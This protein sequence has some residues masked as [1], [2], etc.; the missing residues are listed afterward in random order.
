MKN[1]SFKTQTKDK[2]MK[3]RTFYHLVLDKSG[4]MLDSWVEARQVI[5][6]QLKELSRMQ[7]ENPDSEISFSICAFNQALRFSKEIV[8][9]D[10]AE[11]DWGTIYPDGMTA[12][13]DAIG[14]SIEFVKSKAGAILDA[15][16]SD[17]VMLILTDGLENSSRNY[18]GR[19][20]KQIIEAYEKTGK[21][22]FLFLGAGLD[23][24][25]VTREFGRENKNSMSFDKANYRKTFALINDE[26]EDFVKSKSSG[27]KKKDFF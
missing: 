2:A 4:S 14:E 23:I 3:K 26:L 5:N 9:I 10:K 13:Y 27:Q 18:S 19:A 15:D 12:L 24:N 11:I 16:Q 21:W 25:E 8:N 17:V 7:V 6:N 1:Q 22:N 20:I